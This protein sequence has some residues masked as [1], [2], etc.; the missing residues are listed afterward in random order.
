MC[1]VIPINTI[2]EMI[3]N[4]TYPSRD[5]PSRLHIPFTNKQK[6]PNVNTECGSDSIPTSSVTFLN[7]RAMKGY[8]W[9]MEL[10]VKETKSHRFLD[11]SSG[12]KN[13]RSGVKVQVL[14]TYTKVGY[15]YIMYL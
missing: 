11:V 14:N 8:E 4:I 5:S 15:G 10:F 1:K 13:L 12:A 3:D 2:E 6:I 7:M 9:K